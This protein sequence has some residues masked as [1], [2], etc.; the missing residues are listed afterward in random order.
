M[1]KLVV[2]VALMLVSLTTFAQEGR[3]ANGKQKLPPEQRV[4][5]QIERMSKVL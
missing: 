5:K 3:K 1:K 4:E 2:L